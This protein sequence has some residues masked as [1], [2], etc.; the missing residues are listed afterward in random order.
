[1]L[2]HHADL[3]PQALDRHVAQ[4]VAVD[5]DP[6]LVGVEETRQQAGQGRLPGSGCAD[7]GH[8]FPPSDLER[9]PVQDRAPGVGHRDVVEHDPIVEPVDGPRSRAI[10]DVLRRRHHREDAMTDGGQRLQGHVGAVQLAKRFVEQPHVGEELDQERHGQGAGPDPQTRVHQEQ[11]GD[12][13]RERLDGDR[14]EGREPLD[15]ETVGQVTVGGRH[16]L[17]V[18]VIFAAKGLHDRV[19]AQ[20]F[21][22]RRRDIG[23]AGLGLPTRPADAAAEAREH[24]QEG[25]RRQEHQGRQLE[26]GREQEARQQDEGDRLLPHV[27]QPGRQ[28]DLHQRDVVHDPAD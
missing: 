6:P 27:E 5:R 17:R 23:H 7:K 15:T 2:R 12:R 20:P 13:H 4:V 26:V 19:P 16:E 28:R 1:M 3:R 8:D 11:A 22:Q 21:Q 24:Q 18:L 25:R 10:L 9:N 14:R